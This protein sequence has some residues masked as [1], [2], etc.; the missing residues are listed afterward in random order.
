MYAF[1][2]C[3]DGEN[4]QLTEDLAF[5]EDVA[6]QVPHN[7]WPGWGRLNSIWYCEVSGPRGLPE[8]MDPRLVRYLEAH[9][10]ARQFADEAI[11]ASWL[12][13]AEIAALQQNEPERSHFTASQFCRSDPALVESHRCRM[14]FWID[15]T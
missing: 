1:A 6:D 4:W 12:S 3:F 7:A 2:E 5:D 13:H 15:Q 10:T 9:W 14:V 8:H 11:N